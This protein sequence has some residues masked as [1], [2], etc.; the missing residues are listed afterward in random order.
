[1]N[2]FVF[3]MTSYSSKPVVCVVIIFSNS[4]RIIFVYVSSANTSNI[5]HYSVLKKWVSFPYFFLHCVYPHRRRF[6]FY[7]FYFTQTQIKS[8]SSFD[9]QNIQTFLEAPGDLNF[10]LFSC[11]NKCLK[12]CEKLSFVIWSKKRKKNRHQKWVSADYQSSNSW[13]W[14]VDWG[15]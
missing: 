12:F 10:I 15:I 1:M 2:N 5:K 3:L 9:F 13:N 6:E 7:S 4:H 11:N 8:Q 14:W